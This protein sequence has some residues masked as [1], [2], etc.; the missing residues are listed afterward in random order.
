M[1]DAGCGDAAPHV[2]TLVRRAPEWLLA[3]DMLAR[4]GG[5]DCGVGVERVGPTVVE[6]PDPLIRDDVVP[7]R[8]PPLVAVSASGLCDRILVPPGDGDQPW[9]ERGSRRHVLELAKGVRV[10]LPHERVA[11]H[12]DADLCHRAIVRS[13]GCAES[14]EPQKPSNPPRLRTRVV[15]SHL[16]GHCSEP[17]LS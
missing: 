2:V 15:E 7:V 14:H 3:Q 12:A 8:R 6:E 9:H 16:G 5:G 4:F 13:R 11:E 17:I 1:L 10:R